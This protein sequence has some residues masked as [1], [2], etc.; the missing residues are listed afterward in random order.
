MLY[1]FGV[2]GYCNLNM[3]KPEN[4][5]LLLLLYLCWSYTDLHL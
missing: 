5:T 2:Q 1:A 4:S 3:H